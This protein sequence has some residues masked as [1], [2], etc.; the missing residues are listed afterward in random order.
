[1]AGQEGR[2]LQAQRKLDKTQKARHSTKAQASGS[3]EH[4][5][6]SGAA[7]ILQNAGKTLVREAVGSRQ[8]RAMMEDKEQSP[9]PGKLG[10]QACSRREESLAAQELVR[11]LTFPH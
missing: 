3:R 6:I 7:A 5:L 4:A 9:E 8:H 1:M 11:C 2:G 10:E